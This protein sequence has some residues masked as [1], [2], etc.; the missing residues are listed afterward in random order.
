MA[1][2]DR[3]ESRFIR[4][5]NVGSAFANGDLPMEILA[6]QKLAR[7]EYILRPQAQQN[8]EGHPEGIMTYEE[9]LASLQQ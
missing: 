2:Q 6:L 4:A 1:R 5:D 8:R 7:G 9:L 3:G